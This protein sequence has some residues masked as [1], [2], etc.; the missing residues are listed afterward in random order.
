MCGVIFALL[1]KVVSNGVDVL[2]VDRFRAQELA[3]QGEGDL[4][5]HGASVA[6]R[7]FGDNPGAQQC[8]IM[9]RI[10]FGTIRE[11]AHI[12]QGVAKPCGLTADVD[13]FAL[14]VQ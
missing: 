6:R 2:V 10:G 5:G 1:V 11:Q 14:K 9:K 13:G 12:G 7:L 4:V 3:H 8:A